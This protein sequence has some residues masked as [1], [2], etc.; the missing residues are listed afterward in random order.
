MDEGPMETE[1][2]ALGQ[3]ERDRLSFWNTEP[4]VVTFL[5]PYPLSRQ[6]VLGRRYAEDGLNFAFCA[7]TPL[8]LQKNNADLVLRPQRGVVRHTESH[9][10]THET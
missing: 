3:R 4:T 9:Q 6:V 8:I 10:I 5:R 7:G 2:I 1:R